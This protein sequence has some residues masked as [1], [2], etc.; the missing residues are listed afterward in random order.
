MS[1]ESN[2]NTW[3]EEIEDGK[4]KEKPNYNLEYLYDK[5][6]AEMS[7]QQS[8]RDQII[9]IYLALFSFLIPFAL[10][11]EAIDWQTKGFLFLAAGII[12]VFFSLICIRYRIYKEAYW[13][14]CQTITVLMN[15][16]SEEVDKELIQKSF[17]HCL[18][19]KG[20]GYTVK[21][22]E[23]NVWKTSKF[24]KKNL[25]SAETMH[26]MIID[27][28]ASIIFGLGAGLIFSVA[29]CWKLLIGIVGGVGLFLL[30]TRKYF[31]GLGK[32]YG[33]AKLK[34]SQKTADKKEKDG[35]FNVAFSKAWTL[36]LYYT[37]ERK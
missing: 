6:Y 9:T 24:V 26:F 37:S 23:R 16:K 18:K 19:K 11:Q 30:L 3:E 8:K 27:L 28:M 12:G 14:A 25:F 4:R 33:V 29:V 15:F 35:A 32:I 10:G 17:Y 34:Y 7:L 1:E 21:I 20:K 22:G 31:V 2:R 13:L 5:T 36:H